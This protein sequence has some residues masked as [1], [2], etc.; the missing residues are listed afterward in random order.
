MMGTKMYTTIINFFINQVILNWRLIRLRMPYQLI[1]FTN[2]WQW[3]HLFS[4]FPKICWSMAECFRLPSS[5]RWNSMRQWLHHFL[6]EPFNIFYVG[7]SALPFLQYLS[8]FQLFKICY[9]W[10]LS[11][12]LF[13]LVQFS[14]TLT[15]IPNR[16]LYKTFAFQAFSFLNID[17]LLRP[18]QYNFLRSC[19][20][21]T[22]DLSSKNPPVKF[23]K[24]KQIRTIEIVKTIFTC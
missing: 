9:G 10:K 20:S 22:S 24:Q 1:M 18:M 3:L 13:Q 12:L 15:F 16:D 5:C 7:L 4:N 23:L 2:V 8:H 21:Q 17:Q 14:V 6:E 19:F 11:H